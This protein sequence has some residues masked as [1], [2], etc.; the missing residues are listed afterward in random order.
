MSRRHY[1]I[2]HIADPHFGNCHFAGND[3]S[4]IG[5]DHAKELKDTLKSKHLNSHFDAII[6]S[7]DFSFCCRPEGFRAAVAFVDSI[8]KLTSRGGLVVIPGNHDIDLGEA[9]LVG[10]LRVPAPKDVSERCYRDFLGE[11]GSRD[12]GLHLCPPNRWLMSSTRVQHK[13]DPGLVI[14]GLNSCRV[15][16]R[17]AQG[18]GYIGLDQIHHLASRLL[19]KAEEGDFILAVMHHNPLPIWDIGLEVLVHPPERRKFSFVMDA[20]GVLKYLS[21][22]G[23][24]VLLHGHTHDQSI[25]Q[26]DGYGTSD[27]TRAGSIRILG[28]GSLG[29]HRGREDPPHHFQIIELDLPEWRMYVQDLTALDQQKGVSREWDLYKP[30]T[31]ALTSFWKTEQAQEAMKAHRTRSGLASRD[32]QITESWSR[33]WIKEKRTDD[34]PR[35]LRELSRRVG[36]PEARVAAIVE[37]ICQDP[38]NE[39]QLC[40]YSLEEWIKLLIG[41]RP[42]PESFP[43]Q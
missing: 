4:D 38:P 34:W 9:A 10:K 15:E 27:R 6:L 30:R 7:G 16:R 3:P 36:L 18:W 2:L 33:L 8:A 22:L 26:V 21:D 41:S 13:G 42:N 25:K 35:E 40:S 28:A 14:A 12:F 32:S 1:R 17:D 39:Y 29:V 20:G 24:G 23:I 43:S 37:G 19:D 11:I 31:L 5:G